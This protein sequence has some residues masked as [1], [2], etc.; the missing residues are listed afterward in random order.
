MK[1]KNSNHN[2]GHS[3]KDVFL[4][5][6]S[7]MTRKAYVSPDVTVVSF[8]I[9]HGYEASGGLSATSYNQT[10]WDLGTSDGAMSTNNYG[11]VVWD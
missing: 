8:G 5:C 3:E 9:E 7:S 1:E 4:K 10:D 2:G 6:H 11:T